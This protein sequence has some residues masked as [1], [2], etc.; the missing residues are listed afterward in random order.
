MG[1]L[2]LLHVEILL[3]PYPRVLVYLGLLQ[4]L[5]S[6]L[7]ALAALHGHPE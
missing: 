5:L 7:L 6:C 2:C 1:H 3:I 4:V